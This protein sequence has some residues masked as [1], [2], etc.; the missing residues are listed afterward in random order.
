[1]K[2]FDLCTEKRTADILTEPSAYPGVKRVAGCVAEDLQLVTGCRP[3]IIE[4]VREC[5]GKTVIFAATVG[6]SPLAEELIQAGK[7]D[8][9][10]IAGKREVYSVQVAE[11]PFAQNPEIASA[12]VIVGSDKRGTIY[13]LFRVSEL[14]GVSPLVYWGDVM[15]GKKETVTLHFAEPYVSKEPSVKYRGFFINDEWPAFGKWCTEH[16]GGVNAKAYEK[17]FELLLRL[18]GNYFWPA[19]W[20]S[21]FSEDGPGIENARLADEYGVIMGTSHHEPLCRAGVE[22]QRKYGQYGDDSTWSF[23]SN[24]D[25]ITRFWE[26][27][28]LRNKAFENVITIGMRGEDDSK[29]LPEDA[30]LNDNIEVIKKAVRTQNQ[31][32]KKHINEN[33]AD[34]PRML[35]IY[36]EVEDYY[37]GDETC[38]GLR[39]W[40]ELKDVI[41]L[42]SDDNYGNLRG[43]PDENDLKHP[44]GFG[45]YYH[46]DYH[47]AP[48]S[49]EW[50]NSSRLSKTWEQMTTAYEHG[51][52]DM[53]IVNVG[54]LK[55]V[56]YPLHYFMELAYDYEKW[57]IS[58]L[59]SAETFAA[60]WVEQQFPGAGK[61]QKQELLEVLEGFCKWNGAR[62]PEGMN[63]DVYH[64]VHFNEGEHVW[65]EVNGL[66]EKADRLKKNL[67]AECINAYESM[68]YYPAVTS[69]NLILMNIEAGGNKELAKR[70]SMAANPL[71]ISIEKRIQKDWTLIEEYHGLMDGKWCH[72]MDSA[73]NGFRVWDDNNW[74]YPAPNRVIPLPCAKIL[75]SFRG[76]DAYNLGRHWQD[77]APICND[78]FTRPD[79]ESI[80]IDI[81]SRGAV[82]FD[83]EILCDKEWLHFSQEKGHVNACAEGH[84]GVVLTCD[85]DKLTGSEQAA[86]K[87]QF[88]FAN[89]EEKLALLTV[90][91]DKLRNEYP[92]CFVEKQGYIAIHAEH[93]AAKEDVDGAGWQKV[94][95]L[96]RE[97]SA[98]KCFP[99]TKNW[100]DEER[101]PA[102][103]YAFA[104]CEEGNYRLAFYFAARNP[105]QRGGRM[106]FS[107]A[108]NDG[109]AV[110][111]PMVRE[112][113]YTEW[114]NAE[115]NAGVMNNARVVTTSAFV[116]K[117]ENRLL[118]YAGDSGIILEKIVL[119]PEKT[120]L[121]DS[122]FG[123]QES[124]YG[125]K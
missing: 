95:Q 12:L 105:A 121:P 63:A 34:V 2:F 38:E 17:V 88:H 91:A 87:I 70:G 115:W 10:G 46:F 53:W 21:S 25:A 39:I 30:T 123:P 1:M 40:D 65:H 83:Y 15:P 119:Y 33:L 14:C 102:L 45:M 71:L 5:H 47:G 110:R 4:D 72:M 57:G 100:S 11:A 103:E 74:T 122:Y 85:R 82:D 7:L 98:V 58:D 73:H 22:W 120:V 93:F 9:T 16:F 23:L 64:P 90:K 111:L 32:I 75:V 97:T 19:M 43:L 69:L 117:G 114:R 62:R 49:Y 59:H 77:G 86:L 42:L 66:I 31:L 76:S 6:Q 113:Y 104:A 81:D 89:G 27:G 106:H 92:G 20:R 29:L 52:R 18:K 24:G 118:F 108:V 28:L 50:Q 3:R 44:G 80:T 79:T 124:Y 116:R 55:G 60:R 8:V 94:A 99:V 37:Y 112:D 78:A 13:G 54:D 36:K 84:A 35:A 107:F 48:V 68:I 67:P 56:E 51:V 109:E 26:E 101:K 61:E 41:F 96:G 125:I